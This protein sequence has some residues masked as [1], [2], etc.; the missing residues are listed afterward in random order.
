MELLPQL[1][2]LERSDA[3]ED[4]AESGSD[5]LLLLLLCL[6]CVDAPVRH[7]G[8]PVAEA[9]LEG[10]SPVV[11]VVV[12]VAVV[13]TAGGVAAGAGAGAAA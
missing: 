11:V 10:V 8:A 1:R 6:E 2:P 9:L 12:E 5:H 13:L 7:Y 3:E 4:H